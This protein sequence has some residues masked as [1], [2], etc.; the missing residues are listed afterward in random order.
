MKTDAIY[1]DLK[2]AL[3]AFVSQKTDK[4]VR[5][6]LKLAV[7]KYFEEEVSRYTT[8]ELVKYLD[9]PE[10]VIGHFKKY[11]DGKECLLC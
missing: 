2:E 9:T 4:S 6:D 10:K 11:I 5:I 1:D 3:T 7:E 8:E